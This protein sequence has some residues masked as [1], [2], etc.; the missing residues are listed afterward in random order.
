MAISVSGGAQKVPASFRH[1][2]ARGGAVSV[3]MLPSIHRRGPE[4]FFF[5]LLIPRLP[6]RSHE[7]DPISSVYPG[8][9]SPITR[10]TLHGETISRRLIL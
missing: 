6:S 10:P 9:I 4:I 7:G 1:I 3:P 8:V 2:E 5:L